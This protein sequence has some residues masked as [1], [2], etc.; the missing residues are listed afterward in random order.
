MMTT[1][2]N[3]FVAT[4][5]VLTSIAFSAAGGRLEAAAPNAKPLR[6]ACVG[7]SITVGV[8]TAVPERDAYPKQLAALLGAGW[9]VRSF[10]VSGTTVLNI[11]GYPWAG[12]AERDAAIASKPDVVIIAL[13]TNDCNPEK[14]SHKAHYLDDYRALIELF[15][16]L[17]SKPKIYVATP[18]PFGPLYNNHI[19]GLEEQI[20]LIGQLAREEKLTVIDMNTALKGREELIPDSVHP[21]TIGAGIMARTAFKAL[22]GREAPSPA[23]N[24]VPAGVVK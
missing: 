16:K 5:A 3:V 10:G 14:W 9:D 4:T 11:T 2:R 6:V 8:G 18:V 23:A 21:N 20:V 12:T 22:T 13:G 19:A 24:V 1:R 17:E 7:D 15:R